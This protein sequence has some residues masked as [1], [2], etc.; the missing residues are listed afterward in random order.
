M[1]N[2]VAPT[3][4]SD[5][6]N[7]TLPYQHGSGTVLP[8]LEACLASAPATKRS[9]HKL[10]VPQEWSANNI[11]VIEVR[12]GARLVVRSVYPK[13]NSIRAWAISGELDSLFR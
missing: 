8:T 11:N 2:A 5:W 4:K 13:V 10:R 7:V 6:I 3:M 1:K 9:A 12:E